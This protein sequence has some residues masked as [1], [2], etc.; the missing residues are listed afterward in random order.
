MSEME[1][2][3]ELVANPAFT[4]DVPACIADT[5]GNTWEC[6]SVVL[7]RAPPVEPGSAPAAAPT[8]NLSLKS[9]VL[10]VPLQSTHPEGILASVPL[11]MTI[12]P[13][14]IES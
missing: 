4:L 2:V 7:D 5:R 12:T 6:P 8:M 9:G 1:S 11:H 3:W 13:L 10:L 14:G